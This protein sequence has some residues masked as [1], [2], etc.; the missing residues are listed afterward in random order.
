MA[1]HPGAGEARGVGLFTRRPQCDEVMWSLPSGAPSQSRLTHCPCPWGAANTATKG[2]DVGCIPRSP[3][4][5]GQYSCPKPWTLGLGNGEG[6]DK[7]GV[8][9]PLSK[10][11]KEEAWEAS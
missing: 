3:N 2:R 7:G 10:G 1:T 5:L 11:R 8:G 4:L 9:C 6:Q